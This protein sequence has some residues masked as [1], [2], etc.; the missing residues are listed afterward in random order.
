MGVNLLILLSGFSHSYLRVEAELLLG[1]EILPILSGLRRERGGGLEP[2]PEAVARGAQRQLRVDLPLAGDVDRREEQ[3]AD[4]VEGGVAVVVG[5]R[6][7]L[8]ELGR[9]PVVGNVPGVE[10]GRRRPSLNLARVQRPGEVLGHLPEDAALAARLPLLDPVPVAQ[11]LA[12]ALHLGRPEHM[13]MAADQ[14]LAAVLGH[15]GP[16]PLAALLEQKREEVD[17][18]E[19]VAE[20][21]EQLGVVGRVGGVGQLVG[22]LH[23]VRHDRA[24][25]LLG[26][27][28]TLVPQ[29]PREVV[30]RLERLR[31]RRGHAARAA[32]RSGPGPAGAPA[33]PAGAPAGP[34][35]APAGP[36]GAPAGPAGAPAGPAAAAERR[37]ASW[38]SRPCSPR[39][40]SPSGSPS[41]PSPSSG[42]S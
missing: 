16:R 24:L 27:P 29:P 5:H 35:G 33:G 26:V 30:E 38:P 28:R 22:L 1:A 42:T 39:P 10:P 41:A 23:G 9:H 18:E 21:V 32:A 37:S 36:A 12:G 20:L 8:L 15:L 11:D 25:V 2:T 40:C 17:L 19:D 6:A 13:R 4:L 31:A 7:Q 3:V 14:L 34:A